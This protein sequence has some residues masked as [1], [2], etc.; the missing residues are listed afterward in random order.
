MAQINNNVSFTWGSIFTHFFCNMPDSISIQQP[1]TRK[2]R[3]LITA[4]IMC[5]CLNAI[6]ILAPEAKQ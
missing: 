1:R 6:Y 5:A 4:N 2:N 3:P